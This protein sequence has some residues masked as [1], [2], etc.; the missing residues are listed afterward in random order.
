VFSGG[1][2]AGSA[3]KANSAG[4]EEAGIALI[5][6]ARPAA[7]LRPGAELFV[8]DHRQYRSQVLVVSDG[9]LADLAKL[10]EGAV[11]EVYLV[12]A[13]RKPA[14]RI[15]ETVTYLPIAALAGS[16]GSTMKI[17]LSYCNVSAWERRRRC[18]FQAKAFSRSS[19]ARSGRVQVL[20]IRRKLSKARIVIG[21]EC[22]EQ[23]VAFGRGRPRQAAIP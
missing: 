10:V 9:A 12:I 13:D 16:L 8:A 11:G 7:T 22:R 19:S 23:A 1:T 17:T 3:R 20:L 6:P 15:V 18:S 14:I 21:D 4:L 5:A 2:S